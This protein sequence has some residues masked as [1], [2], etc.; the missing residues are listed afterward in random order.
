VS[1]NGRG[2]CGC[3]RARC[4]EDAWW[5]H[6]CGLWWLIVFEIA[7]RSREAMTDAHVDAWQEDEA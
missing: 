3:G 5:F 4:R 6:F 1:C 7:E 2:I